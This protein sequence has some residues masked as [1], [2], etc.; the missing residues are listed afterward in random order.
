MSTEWCQRTEMLL[1]REAIDLLS[2][3]HVAVIGIGGV[4]GYIVEAL[5]RS[6]IGSLDLIDKDE[7]SESNLNRQIIA[8]RKTLGKNK[9]EVARER[10][11]SINPDCKV[12]IHPVFY[13]P[14]TADTF[15][16]TQ[17]DYVVDAIDT[18][19]G[20]LAIIEK[21]VREGVPVISCMGTGN[22]LDPSQLRVSDLYE[23]SVCPLA[24]VMRRECRKR[25][26]EKLKVVYS[27]E[28]PIRPG[29]AEN[30]LGLTDNS[31]PQADSCEKKES[32]HTEE[33]R[34]SESCSA[35]RRKDTP[36]SACFVPAA[37]GLLI[38]SVVVRDIIKRSE[39]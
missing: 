7:V 34:E 5:V 9:T 26:I 12:L 16:F 29:K 14:E 35:V 8:T 17:Y 21:A 27:K 1:G 25:G 19:T 22:K 39:Q 38:A 20:K 15:D 18:V 30:L 28:E 31:K 2:K 23:T 3:A 32:A 36:G 33:K 13:L 24:K 10:V 11:L 37:A 6:G 4:G